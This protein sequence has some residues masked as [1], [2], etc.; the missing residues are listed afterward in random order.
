MQPVSSQVLADVWYN[1]STL[2]ARIEALMGRVKR[3]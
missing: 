1:L 2:Q 3:G